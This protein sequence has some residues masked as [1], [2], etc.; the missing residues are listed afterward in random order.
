MNTCNICDGPANDGET[1]TDAIGALVERAKAAG[2]DPVLMPSHINICGACVR[3]HGADRPLDRAVLD[4]VDRI[5]AR[6]TRRG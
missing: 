2:V 4:A 3:K 6:L 5:I 1:V